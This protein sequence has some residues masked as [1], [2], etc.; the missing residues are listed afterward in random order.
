MKA[1]FKVR[2][3]LIITIL[4]AIASIKGWLVYGYVDTTKETLSVATM[5]TF[6]LAFVLI[7]YKSIKAFRHDAIKLY[8]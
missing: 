4:L 8:K 2:W 1:V 7:G 3:E 6:L 5:T